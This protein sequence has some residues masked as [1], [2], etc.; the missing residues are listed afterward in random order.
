MLDRIFPPG[1]MNIHLTFEKALYWRNPQF[2]RGQSQKDLYRI[3]LHNVLIQL[4]VLRT[5]YDKMQSKMELF[6]TNGEKC[7]L[8]VLYQELS[9][10]GRY[11]LFRISSVNI[12]LFI[13]TSGAGSHFCPTFLPYLEAE[14]ICIFFIQTIIGYLL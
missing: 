11:L 1:F 13:K 7:V 2:F 12:T 14:T 8:L 10:T 5:K 4:Q 6:R 3:S 9:P